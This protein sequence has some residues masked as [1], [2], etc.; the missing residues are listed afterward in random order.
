[1]H[2]LLKKSKYLAVFIKEMH[3][4]I[5]PICKNTF[6]QSIRHFNLAGR[7]CR[8]MSYPP[9]AWHHKITQ[10]ESCPWTHILMALLFVLVKPCAL[11]SEFQLSN[12]GSYRAPS[13]GRNWKMREIRS[14]KACAQLSSNP[15]QKRRI[16][17]DAWCFRR[18]LPD[19]YSNMHF[20][21]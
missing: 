10:L 4:K 9:P 1:M 13:A 11:V 20:W 8:R 2:P 16:M 7:S 14:I 12:W 5:A 6:Y 15:G 17:I 21:R 18:N 19:S 3:I